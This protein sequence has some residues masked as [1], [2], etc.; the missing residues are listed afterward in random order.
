MST[1]LAVEATRNKSN[2]HPIRLLGVPVIKH[3][4]KEK[5]DL[6]H[7]KYGI[8][9][10]HAHPAKIDS[11][12]FGPEI[13]KLGLFTPYAQHNL[14]KSLHK[15]VIEEFSRTT[16]ATNSK[17]LGKGWDAEARLISQAF[18]NYPV[19]VVEKQFGKGNS[20]EET[21][22]LSPSGMEYAQLIEEVRPAFDNL[23]FQLVYPLGA[24]QRALFTEYIEGSTLS[25][26]FERMK[27]MHEAGTIAA[28]SDMLKNATYEL[29]QAV[30]L[31]LEQFFKAIGYRQGTLHGSGARYFE[32]QQLQKKLY[33]IADVDSSYD[34][35]AKTDKWGNASGN[36]NWMVPPRTAHETELQLSQENITNAFA[37]LKSGMINIDPVEIRAQGYRAG[38]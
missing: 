34:Y 13:Q 12:I 10:Y 14:P 9:F 36:T 24:T 28:L 1:E 2:I 5:G 23:G 3:P 16:Y 33:V 38:Y 27:I 20:K 25:H 29:R 22:E 17:P 21:L 11:I 18:G 35:N 7:D 26:F 8:W 37:T 32:N 4:E 19:Q 15:K 30:F 31:Q 6:S